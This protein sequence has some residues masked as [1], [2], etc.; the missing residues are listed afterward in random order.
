MLKFMFCQIM[1][2]N[3]KNKIKIDLIIIV[4][5]V[6]KINFNNSKV[7]VFSLM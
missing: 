7:I 2:E 6:T 3:S 1:K 5:L 4:V